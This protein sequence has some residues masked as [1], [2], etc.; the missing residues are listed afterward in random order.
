MSSIPG[1]VYLA[2]VVDIVRRSHLQQDFSDAAAAALYAL[3]AAVA[4]TTGA[5]ARPRLDRVLPLLKHHDTLVAHVARGLQT[6]A[7]RPVFHEL[8]HRPR[9]DISLVR[10]VSYMQMLER[11][12][13]R[14]RFSAA[15]IAACVNRTATVLHR[16]CPCCG[17]AID[18]HN[19]RVAKG[20]LAMMVARAGSVE[21]RRVIPVCA[22][23]A[24]EQ[25]SM[26]LVT[27]G[28]DDNS[29]ASALCVLCQRPR[30]ISSDKA[31]SATGQSL[32]P[33]CAKCR[34]HPLVNTST[35]H[36]GQRTQMSAPPLPCSPS[37]QPPSLFIQ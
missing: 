33:F 37:T 31:V 18:R 25:G 7:R 24:F 19:W 14:E 9:V 22:N 3:I 8:K 5:I 6:P 23:C 21:A 15:P 13:R 34:V 17:G 30:G 4:M 11:R 16:V 35:K 27:D 12:L 32:W 20:P 36:L 26:T 2:F 10:I 1:A 29:R 28:R